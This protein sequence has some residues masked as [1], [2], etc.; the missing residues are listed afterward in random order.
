MYFKK[1]DNFHPLHFIAEKLDVCNSNNINKGIKIVLF[2]MKR[3]HTHVQKAQ[4]AQNVNKQHSLRCFFIHTK[5]IKNTKAQKIQNVKKQL[6]LR[7]F[8]YTQ[9]A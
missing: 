6:L 7:Y 5:S 8:L 2:F 1:F 3:F 9:K 4:K